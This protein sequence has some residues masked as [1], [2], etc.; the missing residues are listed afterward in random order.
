MVTLKRKMFKCVFCG[1]QYNY[2]ESTPGTIFLECIANGKL[3]YT[4]S[5]YSQHQ[6]SRLERHFT[7]NSVP[8][9]QINYLKIFRLFNLLIEKGQCEADFLV[10]LPGFCP[11]CGNY[12]NAL[13]LKEDV[14]NCEYL[15]LIRFIP[16]RNIDH[17]PNHELKEIFTDFNFNYW[18]NMEQQDKEEDEYM[19]KRL[20][21]SKT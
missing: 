1:R 13:E 12:N 7:I 11:F 6:F 14:I 10:I 15:P 20:N 16:L 8:L 9:G 17:L 19:K 5:G 2:Y 18:I 3:F 4:K 21:T